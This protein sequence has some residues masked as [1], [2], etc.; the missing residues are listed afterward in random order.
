MFE[1]SAAAALLSQMKD[2][3][4]VFLLSRPTVVDC[5]LGCVIVPFD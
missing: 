1:S 4:G 5:R 3:L 2:T